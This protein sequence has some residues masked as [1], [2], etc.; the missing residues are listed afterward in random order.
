VPDS[1]YR[2]DALIIDGAPTGSTSTTITMDRDHSVSVTFVK[3]D[4]TDTITDIGEIIRQMM[5]KMVPPMMSMMGMMMTMSIMMSMMTSI[6]Q[7]LA[8]A[9]AV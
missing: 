8:G 9:M 7:S 3:A 5:E 4:K 6:M 1:G 2:V